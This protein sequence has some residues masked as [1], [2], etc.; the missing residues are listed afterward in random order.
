MVTS[1]VLIVAPIVVAEF[2]PSSALV[3]LAR[4][5]SSGRRSQPNAL[6][7]LA[8]IRSN[9]TYDAVGLPWVELPYKPNTQALRTVLNERYAPATVNRSLATLRGVC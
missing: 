8:S 1:L 3:Y 9:G 4:L 5:S 6:N 2:T 7:A